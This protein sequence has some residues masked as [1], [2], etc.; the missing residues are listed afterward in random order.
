[1][2]LKT[3]IESNTCLGK[4][5]LQYFQIGR[6]ILRTYLSDPICGQQ[7]E[8]VLS[9]SYIHLLFLALLIINRM[10]V[11]TSLVISRISSE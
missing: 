7:I 11:M 1:M 8:D 10:L 2:F 4:K 6:K 9:F 5:L 3:K